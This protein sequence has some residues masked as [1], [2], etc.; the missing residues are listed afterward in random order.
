M[1][2]YFIYLAAMI[3]P[4]TFIQTKYEKNISLA[5]YLS[6]DFCQ[7]FLRVNKTTMNIAEN[8]DFRIQF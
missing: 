6:T 2:Q 3:T 1:I 5:D 4:E 7:K 8:S